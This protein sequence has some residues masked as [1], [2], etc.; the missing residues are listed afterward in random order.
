[1]SAATDDIIEK[2]KGLTVS[3]RPLAF[4]GV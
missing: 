2:M 4:L 3:A 1:M